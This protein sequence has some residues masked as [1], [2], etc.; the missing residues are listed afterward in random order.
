MKKLTYFLILILIAVAVGC[1]T[2]SKNSENNTN[3]ADKVFTNGKIYTVNKTLPWA[4]TVAIKGNKIIFV[5]TNEDAKKHISSTTKTFD[6]KGKMMLPGFIDTHQHMMMGATITAGLNLVDALSYEDH[7]EILKN[8]K[9]ENPDAKEVVGFG[10][11]PFAFKNGTKRE[12]LD[13]IF[14][15]GVAVVLLE[16]SGHAG[17]ANT[18]ALRQAGKLKNPEPLIPG[19]SYVEKDENGMATGYIVETPQTVSIMKQFV[20]WDYNYVKSQTISQTSKNAEAGITTVFDAGVPGLLNGELEA[21]SIYTDLASE[22]EIK[23]RIY[24][25]TY[26]NNKNQTP[27][28]F[29]LY[30]DS[31]GYNNRSPYVEAKILKMN[32]DGEPFQ[33][34]MRML[35]PYSNRS[36][37]YGNNIFEDQYVYTVLKR[38]VENNIDVH[39]H[40]MGDYG[41]RIYL[42]AI[43]KL[44]KE[45]PNSTTRFSLA[46]TFMIDDA[47]IKRFAELDV[48]ASFAGHWIANTPEIINLQP[49]MGE[50][51]QKVYPAKP[52]I[53]AGGKISTGSDFAASGFLSTYKILP[54]IEGLVTRKQYN[55]DGAVQLPPANYAITL[56]EAIH[57]A[58]I[59][60][61]YQL[62]KEDEFGSIEVGKLADLVILEKNLFDI[63]SE[64]IGE[65]KVF[66]TLMDGK[67]TFN[68]FKK[69]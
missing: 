15:E 23:Q 59:N 7:V 9:D 42:D 1:N 41:V 65:V 53:N 36:S 60:G 21:L 17:W 57:A 32:I 45:F 63:K 40:A 19:F 5:G 49:L 30:L 24:A 31:L 34:T 37:V 2:K 20:E 39:S 61:A 4:E 14:G 38:A 46:H 13:K 33:Y 16:I 18:E 22:N 29:L 69:E 44:K 55:L 51:T 68:K 8:F 26:H 62:H 67:F 50:R 43:E 66:A 48:V 25:S 54:Q 64:Q 56:E 58:T 27:F 12:L 3:I 6:L 11:K 35:E 52:L 28:K 10:Y 47:D